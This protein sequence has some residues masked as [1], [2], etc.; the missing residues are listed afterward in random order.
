[1]TE[2]EKIAQVKILVSEIDE[3]LGKIK[4][5]IGA[6]VDQ[7]WEERYT[8]RM[9]IL[10]DIYRNDGLVTDDELRKIA[11]RHNMDMR[12][13]GGFFVGDGSIVKISNDRTALTEK[14][15]KDIQDWLK[16]HEDEES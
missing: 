4:N 5:L 11:E 13:V 9:N 7:E 1:M 16:D 8:R 3:R 15:K 10:A 12:G 6:G 14:R 2:E